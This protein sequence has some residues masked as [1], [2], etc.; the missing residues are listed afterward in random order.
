[1]YLSTLLERKLSVEGIPRCYTKQ[2]VHFNSLISIYFVLY[3]YRQVM[4]PRF[5][6]VLYEYLQCTDILVTGSFFP[7]N[8][9]VKYSK[10]C[11]KQSFHSITAAST[12]CTYNNGQVICLYSVWY[13]NRM[14][15]MS[16]TL[17]SNGIY[18][19]IYVSKI[20]NS[21]QFVLQ[22]EFTIKCLLSELKNQ[23]YS[24]S[25]MYVYS[26]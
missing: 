22:F 3:M 20:Y 19:Y 17:N 14:C 7:L 26:I 12:T 16:C 15:S 5:F 23:F 8:I 9:T 4:S 13:Y 10:H 1:M 11:S 2:L 24:T 21:S 6:T 25:K 18:I